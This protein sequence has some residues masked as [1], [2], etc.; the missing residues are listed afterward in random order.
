MHPL[1][2]HKTPATLDTLNFSKVALKNY[3]CNRSFISF[4]LASGWLPTQIALKFR[5]SCFHL[6]SLRHLPGLYVLL[7]NEPRAFFILDTY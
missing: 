2:T 4:S 3:T 1:H 5:S 7:A 6:L